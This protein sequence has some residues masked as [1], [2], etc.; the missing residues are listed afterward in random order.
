MSDK[1]ADKEMLAEMQALLEQES[2][3]PARKR[4]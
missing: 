2:K 3:K 4:N 1:N